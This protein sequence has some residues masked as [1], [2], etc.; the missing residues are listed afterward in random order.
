MKNR[1]A[2][3]DIVTAACFSDLLFPAMVNLIRRALPSALAEGSVIAMIIIVLMFREW[4]A[5]I[6]S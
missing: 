1:A 5:K 2:V 3:M 4:N 6:I